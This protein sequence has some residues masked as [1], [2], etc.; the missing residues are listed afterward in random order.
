MTPDE[1]LGAIGE[2]CPLAFHPVGKNCNN[3]VMGRG[4]DHTKIQIFQIKV[5]EGRRKIDLEAV[6]EL[7]KSI[8]ETDLINPITVDQDYTLIAGLHR[9]EAAKLLGWTEIECNVTDLEG[10]KAEL[11]EVDENV[12]R[13]GLSSV[14]YNDLLLRRKEIYERLHPETRATYDG[15]A[16]RGNQHQKVVGEIISATTKSFTQDTADKLGVSPRTVELSIQ[17]AKNLTT[18]AKDIIRAAGTKLSK[19]D[20]MRLSR[21]TPEQQADA[22][23]QLAEEKI[24]S[25][26]EYLS[27]PVE[28]KPAENRPLKKKHSPKPTSTP[29]EPSAPS[30]PET[31]YYP[32]IRDSVADLKNPDKDRSPTPDIF[33][34]TFTLFLQ[35]FGQSVKSYAVNESA[36]VFPALTQEH[37]AQIQQEISAVHRA[38]DDLFKIMEKESKK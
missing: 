38:L 31:G 9:L 18:E 33:L 34:V 6:Q 3:K 1:R 30:V 25:V 14:E 13:K 23:S 29:P 4:G 24:Q 27:A 22:A 28:P 36:A 37:L 11:A 8:S 19:K 7:A 20:A 16:F 12:V 15:G 10:L 17:T 2:L 35:R 32:T 5:N 21:L 26:N